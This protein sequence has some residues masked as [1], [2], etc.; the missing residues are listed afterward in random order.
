MIEFLYTLV[1]LLATT[2][3]AVAGLGGG[4]II[5]PML[6]AVGHDNAATVGV[7][8]AV[9]VFTMCV[10]SISRQVRKGFRFNRRVLVSISAGSVLGGIVGEQILNA[11]I[12]R[13]DNHVVTAVQAG[14]LG[15]TLVGIL[16]YNLAEHRVQHFHL[17]HPAAVFGV[18]FG[19]GAISVFLGIGGGPLNIALLTWLFGF[20][21]KTATVYS[22]ATIFFSQAAKLALVGA[23]GGF[24]R[25]DLHLIPLLMVAAVAGGF[26]GT[27]LNQR[28]TERTI[29]RLYLALVCALIALSVYNLVTNLGG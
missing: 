13:L 28:C 10:T 20:T 7:Y 1:V 18:G 6:D 25:H 21:L 24:G 22:L 29:R 16:A 14:L 5:K 17:R 19:L 26:A 8:S 3:G 4:V 9:A 15:L 27:T 11:A 2:I 12:V 23:S